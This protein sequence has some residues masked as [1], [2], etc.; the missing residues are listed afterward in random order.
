MILM[1]KIRTQLEADILSHNP[2]LVNLYVYIYIHERY[3]LYRA[4]LVY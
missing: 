2:D 3:A 1:K 4:I